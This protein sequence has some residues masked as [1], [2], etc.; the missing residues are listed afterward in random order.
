MSDR[1]VPYLKSPEWKAK[2]QSVNK[3]CKGICERCSKYPVDDIHHLTYDRAY[4][5]RLEDLQGLC[6][7]CHQFLHGKSGIDPLAPS[8]HIKV[9]WK[10]MQFWDDK[11]RRFRRIKLESP[12]AY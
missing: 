3:R 11:A 1:Y 6:K 4:C 8:I 5:E 10:L 7:P 9:T 12:L 2:R